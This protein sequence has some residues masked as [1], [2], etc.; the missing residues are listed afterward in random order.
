MMNL[1][2]YIK[3]KLDKKAYRLKQD[4]QKLRWLAKYKFNTIIDVGANEGQYATKILCIF[5]LA[6]VHCFEPLP[7]VFEK[8][9]FD[10]RKNENVTTYNFA[11]GAAESEMTI[12][13]NEYSPSSSLLE[14][15]DLHKDNFSFA[16]ESKPT[17]IQ[18]RTLDSFF[19]K[20]QIKS[21]L[22]LKVDVQG[23]ELPVLEGGQSILSRADAVIIETSYYPLYKDQPLFE[24]IYEYLVSRGFRYV[25]NIDQLESPNDNSVLQADAVFVRK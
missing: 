20:N 12:Y 22:L 16:R 21:P 15:L 24:E 3:Y 19:D 23:Y 4:V 9:K 8:L 2:E 1:I 11:L 7:E 17:K 25:G 5:P 18:V 14:M 6:K 13:R 10:F